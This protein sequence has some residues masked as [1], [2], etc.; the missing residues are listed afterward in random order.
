M[1][2]YF[3]FEDYVA[4]VFVSILLCIYND[5]D[6]I[7]NMCLKLGELDIFPLLM[8]YAF[9]LNAPFKYM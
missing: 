7:R 8:S 2:C 4:L 6:V 5:A 9:Y 3:Y 1:L